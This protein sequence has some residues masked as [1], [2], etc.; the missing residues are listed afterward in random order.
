MNEG[1][2][3][4]VLFMADFDSRDCMTAMKAAY[5]YDFPWTAAS[6]LIRAGYSPE[7]VG[8]A[9]KA[10]CYLREDEIATAFHTAECGAREALR[11]IDGSYAIRFE[12]ALEIVEQAGFTSGEIRQALAADQMPERGPTPWYARTRAFGRWIR[13]SWRRRPRPLAALRGKSS[14]PVKIYIYDIP[15]DLLHFRCKEMARP[16]FDNLK[17]PERAAPMRF[18]LSTRML[19]KHYFSEASTRD[20]TQQ[21][22][23]EF[24]VYEELKKADHLVTRNPEKADFFLVPHFTT[25][26]FAKLLKNVEFLDFRSDSFHEKHWPEILGIANRY[27]QSILNHVCSRQPYFDR[28]QGRDH[29]LLSTWDNGLGLAEPRKPGAY[30]VTHMLGEDTLN[31]L[32]QVIQVTYHGNLAQRYFRTHPHLIMPPY[33]NDELVRRIRTDPRSRCFSLEQRTT[34]AFFL[35]SPSHH[36][37]REVYERH[38]GRDSDM[39]TNTPE[40]K[41]DLFDEIRLSSLF[42]ICM[43]GYTP[44]TMRLSQ[45]FLFGCI[46]VI[47]SDNII[48]PFEHT[49]DWDA[50]SIRISPREIPRL[51]SRLQALSSE[52]IQRLQRG[53]VKY[54]EY[55]LF[56]SRHSLIEQGVGEAM[57]EGLC[58]LK[59][60]GARER[61]GT[62]GAKSFFSLK[63]WV[64]GIAG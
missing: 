8:Q 40:L 18:D 50:C 59:A 28:Y 38:Y 27:L 39:P 15:E 19:R 52:E 47:I 56:D 64:P 60:R 53:L 44:W 33:L 22:G 55:M 2:M 29:L 20:W 9:L 11:A 61:A 32:R 48:L 63:K 58:R 36:P 57:V 46:P 30:S 5:R 13:G 51:K 6:A 4:A 31:R 26:I 62:G 12:V 43:E 7:D 41:S 17:D 23:F 35:G 54:S 3:A 14:S 49:I 45:A 21:Y 34:L 24:V 10:V 37:M 16:Y 1:E 42:S 25:T